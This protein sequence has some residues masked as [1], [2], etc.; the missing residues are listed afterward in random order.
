MAGGEECQ[1]ALA[2]KRTL[3]GSALQVGYLCLVEDGSERRGAR[4]SDEVPLE[5][6]SEGWDG[7]GERVGVST[8]AVTQSKY[9]TLAQIRAPG[10]LLERLQNRVAL[11]ALGESG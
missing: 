7:D 10:G 11:E 3:S 9:S 2:R 4:V 5:T 1:W 8:D 6:A